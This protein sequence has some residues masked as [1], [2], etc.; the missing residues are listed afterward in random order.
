MMKFGYTKQKIGEYVYF[1][2]LQMSVVLLT[3]IFSCIW[4]Y[5]GTLEEES[6]VRTFQSSQT[7][8][9]A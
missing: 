4:I 1:L 3:H 9:P 8:F 5:I 2:K 6:W 7:Y